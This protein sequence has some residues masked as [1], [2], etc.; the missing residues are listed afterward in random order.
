MDGQRDDRLGRINGASTL[1]DGARYN[2]ATNSWTAL[3]RTGAPAARYY[4]TAVWTGS[5]MIVW[6][7]TTAA[8]FERRRA[9]QSRGQQLDGDEPRPA[10]PRARRFHTAVW[11]GSEMIVWGGTNGSPFEQRR[12]LQSGGQ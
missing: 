6:G 4:H 3:S 11:T 1:N 5:E 8:L 12:A 10:R 9:L 7:G 2:P